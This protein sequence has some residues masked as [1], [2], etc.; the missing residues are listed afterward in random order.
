MMPDGRPPV[1]P[2][3]GGRTRPE[4][5]PCACPVPAERGDLGPRARLTRDEIVAAAVE[6]LDE[7]GLAGLSLRRLAERL[8]VQAPSL[9]WH[10]RS[11]RELL[12][13]VADAI[14]Q[15]GVAAWREPSP[16]QDWWEWLA[17]RSRAL[18]GALLAHRDGALVVAGRRPVVES[19]PHVEQYLSVLVAAGLPADEA[20]LT[21][22][23]LT[24]YVVGSVLALQRELERPEGPGIPRLPGLPGPAGPHGGSACR[25]REPVPG[26]R[27]AVASGAYPL[28]AEAARGVLGSGDPSGRRFEHGLGLILAGLRARV[29]QA[30]LPGSPGGRQGLRRGAPGSPA[31]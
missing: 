5:D 30:R 31:P 11:K 26:V 3:P 25:R 12:D 15:E 1:N 17:E 20:L 8:E 7:V 9:Y 29:D 19:L 14:L 21:A 10:V 23:S 27:E 18:R 4:P 22:L 13:L 28:L 6:L 16:G 24:T 2:A